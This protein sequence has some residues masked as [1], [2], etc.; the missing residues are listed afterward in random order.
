MRV[1]NCES[2]YR[3]ISESCPARATRYICAIVARYRDVINIARNTR[4][5][6]S[7]TAHSCRH[8]GNLSFERNLLTERERERES[9]RAELIPRR[10]ARK[11]LPLN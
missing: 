11:D 2:N 4:Q 10:F 3:L 7:V 6:A 5:E 9:L 8:S 1:E